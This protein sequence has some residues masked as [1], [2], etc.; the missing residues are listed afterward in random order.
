MVLVREEAGAPGAS[1]EEL[2]DYLRIS[3]GAEDELLQS[4]LRS[5]TS[6]GLDSRCFPAD[7]HAA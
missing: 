2:K 6:A 3:G 4:L 1:L 7:D 5:A